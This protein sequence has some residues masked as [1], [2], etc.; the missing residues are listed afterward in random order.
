MK[1]LKYYIYLY[2]FIIVFS[3]F[4]SYSQWVK[5]INGLDTKEVRALAVQDTNIFAGTWGGGVYLSTSNG[6]TWTA[7]NKGGADTVD[8]LCIKNNYV[9]A[10]SEDNGM[11]LSTNNGASWTEVNDGFTSSDID[12]IALK[13]NNIFAGTADGVFLSTN[14]GTTWTQINNGLGADIHINCL[15]IKDSNIFTGSILVYKSTN[16]GNNW[17]S[18]SNGITTQFLVSCM[19]VSCSGI[20]SG[21]YSGGIFKSTDNGGFW[22]EV[23]NGLTNRFIL[24]ITSNGSNIFAGTEGDGGG[25]FLSTDN[26]N[27]WAAI[28]NG[29][30]DVTIF[31][32][33]I[34]DSLIFAGTLN[35]IYKASLKDLI[36]LSISKINDIVMEQTMTDTINLPVQAVDRTVLQFTLN[37]D[38][39]AMLPTDSMKIT[40]NCSELS[41]IIDPTKLLSGVANITLRVSNGVDTVSTTFSVTVRGINLVCTISG[42]DTV[43][44]H[45]SVLYT[46][47]FQ[48]NATTRWI[49]NNGS[50]IG[51]I[52]DSTVKI[53]WDT[54]GLGYIKL[55]KENI[56]A[57]KKDSSGLFVA[58]NDLPPKPTITADVTKLTS[59]APTGNQWF[60]D[61]VPLAGKTDNFIYVTQHGLY[62][63]QVT[64]KSC[65]SPFSDPYDYLSDYFNL[66][67]HGTNTVCQNDTAYYSTVSEKNVTETWRVDNGTIIGSNNGLTLQVLWDTSG[68]G[69]VVLIK[70]NSTIGKKD[71]ASVTI[72][73]KE[74]PPKPKIRRIGNA[75][76]CNSAQG[77]QWYKDGV[78]IPGAT[79]N[80]FN[81]TDNGKYSVRVIL[82]GCPSP[83]SDEFDF[84]YSYFDL[85]ITGSQ[86]T[87][88]NDT[89]KYTA[90]PEKNVSIKWEVSNGSIVGTADSSAVVVSWRNAGMGNLVLIKENTSINQTDSSSINVT[91][92][93]IPPTPKI[94]QD[95]DTLISSADQGNQ[96]FKNGVLIPGAT[97]KKFT[98][99]LNGKYTVQ[100]TLNGC[101]SPLSAAYTFF[102]GV[103][104]SFNTKSFTLI[105]NPAN[106]KIFINT[107]N[108]NIIGVIEIYTLMGVRL[109]KGEINKSK[110]EIDISSFPVGIY[111]IRIG[112]FQKIFVKD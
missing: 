20:Y 2:L 11:Y 38:N 111:F 23:N 26:G 85:T 12:G 5:C 64:L 110:T 89:L 93:P 28:N 80:S 49:V 43:C 92:N 66:T 63:V 40:N 52:N 37:S 54:V 75:L 86:S 67:I 56:A 21:I 15:A 29:L 16:N 17:S 34:K 87:C 32:L 58:I 33:T 77:Y 42:P 50:T 104:E 19:S 81:P 78:L 69:D 71:S 51:F 76:I 61:G 88:E 108:D 99:L 96:W 57:G 39:P 44:V 18:A 65:K 102:V 97:G 109:Y 7:V 13:G 101:T 22:T 48:K 60:K 74:L 79:G 107:D 55:I 90:I 100:V 72:I 68:I 25:V 36:P 8:Q 83:F 106:D 45:D 59:S 103:N 84:T 10:G 47:P 105:P 53:L 14:D 91:I 6:A 41:M 4:Q 62:T 30:S 82:N 31:C 95:W 9:F 27:S 94:I 1:T 112:T 24:C 46:N 73:I 35:G 70:E 98:A 3:P